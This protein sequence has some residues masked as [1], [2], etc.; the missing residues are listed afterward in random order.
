MIT[1][2]HNQILNELYKGHYIYQ[3]DH[4]V[5]KKIKCE[6]RNKDTNSIIRTLHYRT[7][8]NLIDL[9]LLVFNEQRNS[10]YTKMINGELL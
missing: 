9:D 6:L 1:Q 2:Y 10:Y 3:H 5:H 8:K 7:L 4:A